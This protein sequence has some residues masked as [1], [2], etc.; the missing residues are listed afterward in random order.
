M[1]EVSFNTSELTVQ[2]SKVSEVLVHF[3]IVR[4]GFD[5]SSGT[6]V[7]Y[8]SI[9][10]PHDR[11]TLHEDFDL[12]A[13]GECGEGVACVDFAEGQTEVELSVRIMPDNLQEGNES[14]HLLISDA[15]NGGRGRYELLKITILDAT[16]R[17][18]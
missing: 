4:G 14:F 6:T 8:T 7:F 3:K 18:Y 5:L 15:T 11:A 10:R 12:F 16:E 17:E 2:E 9:I 13:R 1:P